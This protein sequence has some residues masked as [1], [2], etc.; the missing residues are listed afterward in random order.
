MLVLLNWKTRLC[1]TN[2]SDQSLRQTPDNKCVYISFSYSRLYFRLK[3]AALRMCD[4]R[5]DLYQSA[6]FFKT[7]HFSFILFVFR[8]SFQYKSAI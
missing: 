7:F 2:K 4:V 8:S 6:K 1:N 3:A 5:Q